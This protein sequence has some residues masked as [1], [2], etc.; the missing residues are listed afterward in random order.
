MKKFIEDLCIGIRKEI[1]DTPPLI[2]ELRSQLVAVR[3]LEA[4]HTNK[5]ITSEQLMEGLLEIKKLYQS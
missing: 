3:A 4:M 2:I 5:I 1:T